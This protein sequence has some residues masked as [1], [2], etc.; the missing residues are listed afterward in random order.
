MKKIILSIS[1]LI[2]IIVLG[3]G[4]TVVVNKIKYNKKA[5]KIEKNIVTNLKM[6]EEKNAEE[7]KK[8]AE[9]MDSFR[10]EI[11]E[12]S[13]DEEAIAENVR[14][15]NFV[16]IGDSV[17]EDALS[18]IRA[19]LPNGYYDAKISRPLVTGNEILR[20]LKN[21]GKLTDIIVLGLA[22]NGFYTNR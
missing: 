13:N 2:I 22:N 14:R 1:V 18:E 5:S 4:V 7:A 19:L 11:E 9:E 10:I 16:G 12:L 21:Q 8:L 15:L 20:N 17:F 3:F 6:I